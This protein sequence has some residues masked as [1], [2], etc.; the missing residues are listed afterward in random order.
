MAC[1]V[2]GNRSGFRRTAALDLWTRRSPAEGACA[3]SSSTACED[4]LWP[5]RTACFLSAFFS[6]CLKIFLEFPR[7][8]LILLFLFGFLNL[9]VRNGRIDFSSKQESESGE[10]QP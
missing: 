8:L 2:V 9:G 5:M 4:C 1:L 10:I 7:S 6:R 3:T